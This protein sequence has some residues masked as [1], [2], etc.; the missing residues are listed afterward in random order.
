MTQLLDIPAADFATD[1]RS[2]QP[3]RHHLAEH[4]LL[5]VE[6]VARLADRLPARTVEHAVA[7]DIGVVVPGGARALDATPG[8]VARGIADN[9]C[10]MVL[11]HIEQDPAYNRLL[12]ECL[13]E[14]APLLPGG[15]G[16]MLRRQGFIFLSA[17]GS[18]T[19]AHVDF[20]HN[21]LLQVRGQKTMHTGR[22][23]SP[24]AEQRELE[25]SNST[26]AHRNMEYAP[27][28]TG[29]WDLQPGDGLYV[30]VGKPHWVANGPTVS[31]SLSITW[32]SA[33]GL[34]AEHVH[35][36]NERLRRTGLSP[37]RPGESPRVD[38]GKALA[39]RVYEKA[40]HV[41]S[42]SGS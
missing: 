23:E 38:Q 30:P 19:P 16:A 18:V 9:G 39:H 41:M 1:G 12:D 42:R 24:E 22:F 34:R 15:A 32:R 33:D 28:W 17:P 5:S 2:P 3:I 31:V 29:E 35:A 11:K 8:D 20:E 36:F 13:D 14:V 21:F 10:W 40:R 25:R 27:E 37:R 6:A 4:E 26:S 7:R